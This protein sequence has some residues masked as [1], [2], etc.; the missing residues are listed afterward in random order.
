M[1]S[2]L[3]GLLLL[4]FV[5]TANAAFTRDAGNNYTTD[6]VASLDWLALTETSGQDYSQAEALNIGWRYATQTE[7]EA[8]YATLLPGVDVTSSGVGVS[9]PDLSFFKSLF[10]ITSS[11]AYTFGSYVDDASQLVVTSGVTN[12][13]FYYATSIEI[14]LGIDNLPAGA[15]SAAGTYM[16]RNTASVPEASSIYLLAFGLLGLFGAARR[17]V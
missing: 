5:S 6:D 1:K 15:Y 10:G 13:G 3:A 14:Q 17:K 8:M 11:S 9:E 4:G 12:F 2:L 7:V 16:V